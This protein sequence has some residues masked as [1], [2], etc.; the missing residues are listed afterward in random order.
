LN[1]FAPPR[2]LRRYVTWFASKMRILVK[3]VDYAPADLYEQTPFEATLIRQIEG[4]DRPD[5]WLASLAKP[6][7]WSNEGVETSIHHLVL[8]ARWVGTRIGYGMNN[9]P[10]NIAYVVDESV[11][12]DSRLNLDK[13][14]YVAIGTAA[15][16]VDAT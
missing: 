11:L 8:A 16:A 15:D 6:I 4:P 5:Y 2:Q 13:C 3:D 7:R 14:K 1:E 9:L 10:V 12:N